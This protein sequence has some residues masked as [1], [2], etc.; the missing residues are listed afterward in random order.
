MNTS[1]VFIGNVDRVETESN[2][3]TDVMEAEDI[4]NITPS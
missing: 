4:V 2:T 1:C 3:S